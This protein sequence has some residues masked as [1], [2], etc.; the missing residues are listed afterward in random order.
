[1]TE[2]GGVEYCAVGAIRSASGLF[3]L[4]D[5][6]LLVQANEN[7]KRIVNLSVETE[8]A[9]QNYIG[10]EYVPHWNDHASRTKFEVIDALRSAAKDVRNG[11]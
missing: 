3:G 1:M 5:Q 9:L 11:L 8:Q 4:T 7:Y 10:G 6:M 2:E